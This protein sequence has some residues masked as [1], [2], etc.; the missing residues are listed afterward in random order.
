MLQR[1]E[2]DY[3]DMLDNLREVLEMSNKEEEQAAEPMR[4]KDSIEDE[5]I[6]EDII[7]TQANKT[8]D[9]VL[10]NEEGKIE[11]RVKSNVPGERG[12]LIP[13]I[14]QMQVLSSDSADISL[15]SS[16]PT[17]AFEESPPTSLSSTE[18]GDASREPAEVNNAQKFT[19]GGKTLQL[20]DVKAEDSLSFR[21]EALRFYLEKQLGVEQMMKAYRCLKELRFVFS[22]ELSQL[23]SRIF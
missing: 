15:L 20:P 6:V 18:I 8:L 10:V 2:E 4:E 9:E 12:A 14:R 3:E 22:F 19:L 16:S 13:P 1:D 17:S 23:D 21:T 11:R 5:T 7:S